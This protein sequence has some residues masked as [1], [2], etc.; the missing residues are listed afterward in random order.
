[1]SSFTSQEG[2]ALLNKLKKSLSQLPEKDLISALQYH[3]SFVCQSE[4]LQDYFDECGKMIE[5][6]AQHSDNEKL[7]DRLIAQ[8]KLLASY[9]HQQGLQQQK[10][11]INY[12]SRLGRMHKKLAE[13]RQYLARFD[14]QIRLHPELSPQHSIFQRREKC[15]Q[16]IENLEQ[17]ISQIEI[18][19]RNR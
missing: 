14:D 3:P 16:A 19:G 5:Q 13:Y 2:F 1:M 15:Q 8:F 11:K 17:Q 12:G 10:D 4:V 18:K 9:T 7:N 6:V